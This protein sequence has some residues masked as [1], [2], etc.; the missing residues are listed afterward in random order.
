MSE[1]A[2]FSKQTPEASP[3]EDH[4]MIQTEFSGSWVWAGIY[5]LLKLYRFILLTW[6][7]TGSAEDLQR[8]G[9]PT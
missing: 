4:V 7:L 5:A 1:V 8:T 2:E 6:Y 3:T 9:Q